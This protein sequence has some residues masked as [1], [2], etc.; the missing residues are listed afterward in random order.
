MTGE[1]VRVID[2]IVGTRVLISHMDLS[3]AQFSGYLRLK[4]AACAA[5][6]PNR[7]MPQG[8]AF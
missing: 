1:P 6:S 2:C 7:T 3:D 8:R 4:A 5:L